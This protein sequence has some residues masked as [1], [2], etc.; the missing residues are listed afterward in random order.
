MKK[1]NS[2]W[3]LIFLKI[4]LGVEKRSFGSK[5]YLDL[6]SLNIFEYKF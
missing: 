5:F 6:G 1:L 4:N 2:N 3:H